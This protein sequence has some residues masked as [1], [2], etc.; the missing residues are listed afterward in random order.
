MKNNKVVARKITRTLFLSQGVVSAALITTG[1][2]NAIAGAE[3]SGVIAWAGLPATVLLLTAALGALIWGLLME[4]IGRRGG[5]VI[6]L[7]MGALGGLLSGAALWRESFILFLVG[8]GMFGF[9]Q[10]AMQLGRFAA[11][12]VNPAEKRGR[13]IANVVLGG[14]VGAIAGPLLVGPAG[15]LATRAGLGELVGP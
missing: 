15:I 10:A 5:L 6:G 14:T 11:A 7:S 2:V 4:R 9:G 1:T 12:E 3:L 13:A 8:M